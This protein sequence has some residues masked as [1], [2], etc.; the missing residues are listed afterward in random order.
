MPDSAEV[1]LAVRGNRDMRV[2]SQYLGNMKGHLPVAS[3][4][5]PFEKSNFV[6][7][8]QSLS[9]TAFSVASR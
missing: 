6:F 7:Q 2:Q 3:P 1:D 9:L 5:R 4:V 8:M